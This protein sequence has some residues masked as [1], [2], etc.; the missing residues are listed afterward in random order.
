MNINDFWSLETIQ[1]YKTEEIFS[2]L[3]EF[4][5][6]L[7]EA[8]F[9]EQIQSCYRASELRKKW[10]TQYEISAQ[11]RDK[12]FL[13][14]GARVLWERLAPDCLNAEQLHDVIE[15]G[16]DDLEEEKEVQKTCDLWLEYWEKFKA[17]FIPMGLSFAE[18]DKKLDGGLYSVAGWLIEIADALNKFAQEDRSYFQKQIDYCEDVLT[19]FPDAE[20]DFVSD[21]ISKKADC[22]FELEQVEAGDKC[23]DYILTHYPEGNAWMYMYWA[24][25]YWEPNLCPPSRINFDKAEQIYRRGLANSSPEFQSDILRELKVLEKV[26]LKTKGFGGGEKQNVK[27]VKNVKKSKR[28]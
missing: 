5:I 23:Y 18:L 11:G 25:L 7:N 26:R 4:G 2:K 3:S 6:T 8:E 1:N 21:I 22:L 27:K 16:L 10:N 17:R 15:A 14:L 20:E 12:D 9:L 13:S 24:G 19:T 28:K